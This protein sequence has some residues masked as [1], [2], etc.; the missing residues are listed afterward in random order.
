[1]SLG[2]IEKVNPGLNPRRLP[3]GRFI[4]IPAIGA[5]PKK[6]PEVDTPDI[7]FSSEHRVIKGETLWAISRRYSISP[8]LLA[9]AN[10]R[11]L[12]DILKPGEI[13]KVPHRD[14]AEPDDNHQ[15]GDIIN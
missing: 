8:E 4:K 15:E 5:Q 7:R 12:E 13:L 2:L 6:P 3:L 9:A 14:P 10:K 1:V 11:R